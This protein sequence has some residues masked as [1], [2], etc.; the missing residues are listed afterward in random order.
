[1]TPRGARRTV[2]R[3]GI[4]YALRTIG[5]VALVAIVVSILAVDPKPALSGDGL[6]VSL[7]LAGLVAGAALA[8][9]WRE[10]PD[11]RRLGGLS[12]I[13]VSSVV[14]TGVQPHGGGS[15]GVYVV[16]VIAAMRLPLPAAVAV[17]A[18]VLGGE[19]LVTALAVP[20]S[21]GKFRGMPFS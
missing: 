7:S 1:M 5:I 11:S 19:V 21:G 12:L 2:W 13:A 18:V 14:L 10:M 17:S 9:P 8:M 3:V 16:V 6:W 20:D 15:A 4:P